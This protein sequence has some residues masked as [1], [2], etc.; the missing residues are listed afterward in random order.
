MRLIDADKLKESI[1][2]Y[3]GMFDDDG[4]FW[5]SLKAILSGIDFAEAVDAVPVV[6]CKDCEFWHRNMG[7]VDSPNG[8]CFCYNETTNGY[9]FCAYG[10][11]KTDE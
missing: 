6:L 7:M 2:S 11:R 10:E 5:V 8:I 9:D 3:A 4:E 1:S